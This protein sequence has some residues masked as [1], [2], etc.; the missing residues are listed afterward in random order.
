MRTWNEIKDLKAADGVFS[1]DGIWEEYPPEI[2]DWLAGLYLLDGVPIQY[3][4]PDKRMLPMDGVRFFY[5][6]SNWTAALLDGATSIGRATTADCAIDQRMGYGQRE[7]TKERLG[8]RRA[9]LMHEKH[10]RITDRLRKEPDGDLTGF[11]MRSELV[12]HWNGIEVK[13]YARLQK[14][15]MEEELSILRMEKLE[16]Q[17]LLCIFDGTVERVELL[18]PAEALH[19]GTKAGDRR[20]R[21]RNAR[22]ADVGKVLGET[23]VPVEEN[24]R[25]DMAAFV[26][27]LD[28][29]LG[30]PDGEKATSAEVA[31]QLICVA[32]IG[33]FRQGG[34]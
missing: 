31:L 14:G 9:K 13:G 19:F 21:I 11:L 28:K 24:G 25:L 6:D 20:I 4:L 18:E 1:G 12:R 3:V 22:G 23:V 8:S 16:E 10:R 30:L 17:V 2:K 29:K 26:R 32:D 33:E 5:L 34:E 15:N 27:E 7:N